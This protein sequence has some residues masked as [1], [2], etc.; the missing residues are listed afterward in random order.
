[1]YFGYDFYYFYAAATLLLNGKDVYDL[2][3]LRQALSILGRDPGSQV[4]GFPYPPWTFYLYVPFGLLPFEVALWL[5]TAIQ[6]SILMLSVWLLVESRESLW[7]KKS[8]SFQELFF[9]TLLFFPCFKLLYCGQITAFSLLG[10]SLVL[11]RYGERSSWLQGVGL[12]LMATKP[13]LSAPFIVGFCLA[14]ARSRLSIIGGVVLGFFL[15][16]ALSYVVGASSFETYLVHVRHFLQESGMLLQPTLFSA[17]RYVLGSTFSPTSWLAAG[18]CGGAIF[19]FILRDYN[20]SY[21]SLL[22]ITY[23]L[24]VAP[25]A[26]AHDF[27]LLLPHYLLLIGSV[28]ELARDRIRDVFHLGQFFLLLPTLVWPTWEF[29]ALVLPLCVLFFST[30]KQEFVI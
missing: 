9:F 12:A 23:S 15:Q 13:H 2:E 17:V 6:L 19:S 18:I 27:I 30:R 16:C 21:R 20:S 5:W 22:L 8:L 10:L 7:S 14:S 26:W 25:Y 3:Q 29:A 28:K 1:M 11:S 24:C 4:V